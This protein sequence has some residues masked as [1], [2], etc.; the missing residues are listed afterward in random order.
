MVAVVVDLLRKSLLNIKHRTAQHQQ[1]SYCRVGLL[2]KSGLS[3][4]KKKLFSTENCSL[5]TANTNSLQKA[6]F[7]H[8]DKGQHLLKGYDDIHLT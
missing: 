2:L 3:S 5:C 7:I 6:R 4:F 1:I 8:L